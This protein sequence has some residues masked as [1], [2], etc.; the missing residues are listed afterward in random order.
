MFL[1][2]LY[3]IR[4]TGPAFGLL[5]CAL[6]FAQTPG[7]SATRPDPGVHRK[8]E[9]GDARAQFLVA[10]GAYR[11]KDYVQALHW[12]EKSAA[13]GYALAQTAL[14]SIYEEGKGQPK[15]F[16]QALNWLRK[17]ADQDDP[18]AEAELAAMLMRGEGTAVDFLEAQQ[19][20]IKSAGHGSPA[21]MAQLAYLYST[22]F[23][24][25]KQSAY[26]LCAL[27]L[28]GGQSQCRQTLEE[29][30]TK[31]SAAE[32][33]QADEQTFQLLESRPVRPRAAVS[34]K[35]VEPLGA[36][37]SV[38]DV[39]LRLGELYARGIGVQQEQDQAAKW[40]KWAAE[41]G[42]PAAQASLGE[43]YNTGQGLSRNV[44]AAVAWFQK[45]AAQGDMRGERDLGMAY[46]TGT[47]LARDDQRA[48]EW[49]RKAVDQGSPD[50][51][52]MLGICYQTG[53]GVAPNELQAVDLYQ[54]A[55]EKGNGLAM[56]NV[57]WIYATSSNSAVRNPAEA[58]IYASKA[59]EM[60]AQKDPHVLDTLAE[61][62]YA[63]RQYAEAVQASQQ[64]LSLKPSDAELSEH[65]AKYKCAQN[66]PHE[67]GNQTCGAAA[68]ASH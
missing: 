34:P 23:S 22:G 68:P 15:D 27:A 47:G 63:N 40:Y 48:V 56:N 25:D 3:S 16:Q 67:I 26:M 41:R 43:L 39:G 13:Q 29:L 6:S 33:A 8:A 62:Y 14:G 35:D 19:L 2:L 64:A 21:G 4:L 50:A 32:I 1:R 11:A 65:L 66:F 57:A 5:F 61:A 17:A 28:A 53:R 42:S 60:T 12:Y 30:R 54:R 18:A 55:A 58:L 7:N 46:L 59:V 52:A 9:D 51:E 36:L 37:L 24:G 49:L 20:L 44:N 31:M 45:A 10:Y 38:E